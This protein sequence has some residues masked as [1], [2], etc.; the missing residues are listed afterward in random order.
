MFCLE[1]SRRIWGENHPATS[2]PLNDIAWFLATHRV[3]EVRI[4]TLAS[5][6]TVHGGNGAKAVE[7]A[8]RAC[9]LSQWQNQNWID[10]LAAA[11]A[12]AGDFEEAVKWEERAIA[13]IRDTSSESDVPK[14]WEN[15]LKLY[16]SGKPFHEEG[17][18]YEGF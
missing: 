8:T 13:M 9:E 18:V 16:Q 7:Y 5:I 17:P 15:R 6:G 3:P 4:G 12:E 14:E 1:D 2:A 11:Y 10:T